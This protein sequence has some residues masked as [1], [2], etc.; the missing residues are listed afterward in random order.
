MSEKINGHLTP[1]WSMMLPIS[2]LKRAIN[3]SFRDKIKKASRGH[4]GIP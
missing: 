2:G 4:R 1:F 3:R